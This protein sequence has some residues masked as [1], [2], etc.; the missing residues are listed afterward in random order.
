MRQRAQR[1]PC[2]RVLMDSAHHPA[3]ATGVTGQ[4]CL[5]NLASSLST[6]RLA[7]PN[8]EFLFKTETNSEMSS[9]SHVSLC[10]WAYFSRFWSTETGGGGGQTQTK[11]HHRHIVLYLHIWWWCA[12]DWA[13]TWSQFLC[14]YESGLAHPWSSPF[15][16]TLWQ[17]AREKSYLTSGL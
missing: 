9:R 17:P 14:G 5:C 11:T 8:S 16:W 1:C 2:R 13:R 7:W 4:H 3:A 10:M 6:Q 15:W 12:G